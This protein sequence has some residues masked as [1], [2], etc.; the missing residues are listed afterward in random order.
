MEQAFD[1]DHYHFLFLG[2][3]S[4]KSHV[5]RYQKGEQST[6]DVGHEHLKLS[7][8][9]DQGKAINYVNSR[10]SVCRYF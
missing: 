5:S 3:Y 2:G 7:F 6:V 10:T 1:L 9:T 8:S 4:S